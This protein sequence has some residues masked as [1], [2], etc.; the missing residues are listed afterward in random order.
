MSKLKVAIIGAGQIVWASHLPN[1]EKLSNDAEV[2]GICDVNYE[3]AQ[4]TAKQFGIR[5]AFPSV[6][7][8]LNNIAPDAVSVCVPNKF[9]Y[10]TV[11]Y[12]LERG[13]H[14][15]CEKPPAL[16]AGQAEEMERIAE[17]K[18]KILTFNFHFRQGND[19][20]FLKK[21]IREGRFGEI[22]GARVQSIR[23][24]G[25]PG[26]GN[27]TNKEMQGG[28]PLIDIG[29]HMLDLA[30]YMMDFPEVDYVCAATHQKIGTRK[31]I[32]LMGQWDPKE[33]TVEDSAFGFIK[34]KNN[35][36]I[37][38][39][40]AFALNIKEKDIRNVSLFGEYAGASL[41]P[42]EI[43]GENELSLTNEQ[44]PFAE[45]TDRHYNSVKNFV[46]ACLGREEPVVKGREAV[47]VQKIVNSLYESAESGKPVFF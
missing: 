44:Y 38:L 17:E 28:G 3:Q 2:I 39:E 15:L 10:E 14:V 43:Y 47:I 20:Q 13:C 45:D 34:F 46:S 24:R 22:Y 36:S 1:Y 42:F 29:I 33:F 31:G 30:L 12:A 4:K 8:M 40:T 23:R 19:M 7:E 16:T 32:G 27:F 6:E 5:D 21:K 18:N 25:I 26:W 9:H 41:F 37:N 11:C 35:A